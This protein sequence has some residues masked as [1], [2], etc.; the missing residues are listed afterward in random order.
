MKV[1]WCPTAG[2]VTGLTAAYT[3][4]P[5]THSSYLPRFSTHVQESDPLFRR[6]KPY[7]LLCAGSKPGSSFSPFF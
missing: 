3:R 1:M 2:L 6:V 5:F 7:G 4:Q